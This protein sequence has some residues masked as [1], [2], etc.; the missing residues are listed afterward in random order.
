LKYSRAEDISLAKQELILSF[1][2][3]FMICRILFTCS[4]LVLFSISAAAQKT[5]PWTE[6]SEKDAE[7]VLND[8]A[9][10]QTQTESDAGSQPSSTSAITQTT[11]ARESQVRSA[12]AA[13]NAES[14]EKKEAIALHYRVRLLSAKPIRAAFVRMMEIQGAPPEKVAQLRTFVD[15]DFGDYIVVTITMDGNDRKHMGPAMAEINNVDATTLKTTTY[16]ERK[17]GKR[18]PLMDY[19]APVQ[20]GLGAKFV[21]PRMV[22]GKPF[23][24]ATS[25]EVRF[26]TEVGKAVKISKRFKVSE[27]MYDGKLEY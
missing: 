20:D 9:W 4:I 24:E 10:G 25:G 13:K 21:F 7:K 15:R 6:W 23:I 14:G 16:L 26:S 2:E 19:R 22:D 17:D 5:K 1:K 11:A 27:M 12:D 18:V 8:S 3:K